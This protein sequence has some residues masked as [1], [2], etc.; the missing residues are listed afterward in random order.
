MRDIPTINGDWE[1][2]INRGHFPHVEKAVHYVDK[3]G[4]AALKAMLAD[5]PDPRD[6]AFY[7]AS[8]QVEMLL[9]AYRREDWYL[10]LEVHAKALRPYGLVDYGTR[11]LT[12]FGKA[13]RRELKAMDA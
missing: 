11:A 5:L 2:R 4:R 6:Y 8:W 10:P 1:S 7:M 9:T 3:A 13:V 12:N